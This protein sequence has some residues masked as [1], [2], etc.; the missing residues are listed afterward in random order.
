MFIFLLLLAPPPLFFSKLGATKGG[1]WFTFA[2]FEFFVIY[3]ASAL[4]LRGKRRETRMLLFALVLS[5]AAYAYDVG[6]NGIEER[7]VVLKTVLGA[8]SFMTWRYY[9]FFVMGT[10][11]RKHFDFFLRL[12]DRR[13]FLA[14][15]LAGF[16]LA[17]LLPHTES[18]VQEYRRF[19]LGGVAGI[20]L[21]FTFFRKCAGWFGNGHAWGRALQFTGRRTLDIYL[22][23]Y[24]LLPRF[25]LPFGAHVGSFGNPL[26][27]MAVGLLL[28]IAVTALCLLAS[29]ILRLSPLLARLLFGERGKAAK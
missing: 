9:L 16:L 19:A 10:W 18:G 25:L 26:M 28:A 7:L 1:Y 4:L 14:L 20:A 21:V 3:L 2:L 6:Y 23:H 22:L 8:L 11:A 15:C 29:S 17:A 5:M 27:E 24:F 13:D 12:T